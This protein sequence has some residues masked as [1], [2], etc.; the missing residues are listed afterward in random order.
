MK[1]IEIGKHIVSNEDVQN[2]DF[3]KLLKGSKAHILYTDPPWG[4]GNMK[5]WCTLNKRHTGQ[6]IEAMSYKTLIKIIKDM[7]KNHVDGYVFLETGNQ[8]LDETLEDIK[9][10]IYNQ[11]VYSLR[12]KSGSKLLT[13]PVIVG[14]T[15]P[16]LVLPNLDALEGAIDEDSLKIAIPLLAKEGAILLDPTCGMGNSARSAIQNKM[17]F[18][19]N[20]FNSKRLEKTIKSLKKD[21]NIQ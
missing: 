15:N 4:D 16:N 2:V 12:Y 9:D 1:T 17:R 21:E 10:V 6:E 14:T 7:I 20:E 8:W 18:V 5:Y 13:N 11:K 3:N 19:G